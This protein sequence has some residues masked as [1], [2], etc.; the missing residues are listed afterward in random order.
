[1]PVRQGDLGHLASQAEPI[2]VRGLTPPAELTLPVEAEAARLLA[3]SLQEAALALSRRDAV[4]DRDLLQAQSARL[5][6]L[7]GPLGV[8]RLVLLAEDLNDRTNDPECTEFANALDALRNHLHPLILAV[9]A[10]ANRGLMR[11]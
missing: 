1:M 7:A 8:T 4:T 10:A 5:M 2:R 11:A 3:Q 6:V 9:Q